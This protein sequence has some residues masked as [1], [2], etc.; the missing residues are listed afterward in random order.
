MPDYTAAAN[1]SRSL[2]IVDNDRL[3]LRMMARYLEK[4]GYRVETAQDGLDALDI[5]RDY[6]PDVIFVDLVMPKIDGR[7]FC[8]IVRG[9]DDFKHIPL[10]I[11]SAI[12]AEEIEE[13][14]KIEVN[15]CIAKS[16]FAE[17]SRHVKSV[18][19]LSDLSS[20]R[21]TGDDVLGLEGVAPR[22]ITRELLSVKSH[23]EVMLD[24]L[25]EGVFEVNDSGRILFANAAALALVDRPANELL[26]HH[27]GGLFTGE[28]Q[29]RIAEFLAAP[30]SAPV[31]ITEKQPLPLNEY[32]LTLDRVP[33]DD[34]G[35]TFLII[36]SDVSL[37]KQFETVLEKA[38]DELEARVERR[39][40]DLELSN[41]QLKQEINTRKRMQMELL[42]EKNRLQKAVSKIKTLS[43]LLP[44]CSH[45]N[46]IRETDGAWIRLESYIESHSEAGFSHSI[47]PECAARYYPDLNLYDN[48][49]A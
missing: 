24:H 33:M 5:L 40:A 48:G 8:R 36:A 4:E 14:V 39:T 26:G 10:V 9:M 37:R 3:M 31:A 1:P 18:L 35:D 46:K 30:V 6:R 17:T 42:Q 44:I 20:R 23:Y 43:G 34:E 13:V 32:L 38:R 27:F 15:A 21:C 12:S 16:A 19:D 25:K 7:A 22:G 11:L 47:C 29:Q 28:N 45:C 2:L 41:R 49:D